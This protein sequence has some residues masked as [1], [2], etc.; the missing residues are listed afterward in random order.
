MTPRRS[1]DEAVALLEG[2]LRAG[3]R[4][5][6]DLGTEDVW[7][8]FLRFGR[9]LFDVSEAPDGDGLLFQYGTD[10]FDGSPTFTV[11]LTRQFEVSDADGDHDHYL[12]VHCEVRYGSGPS[13]EAL[14]SF[15]SWFFHDSGDNLEEWARALTELSAWTAIKVLTPTE[16][17]VFQE[18]V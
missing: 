4:A 18:R 2:E 8:S 9:Q 14:G 16:I 1:V 7:Q 5:L 17:R 6:A 13:L 15:D 11:D 10:S 3:H 12:Q